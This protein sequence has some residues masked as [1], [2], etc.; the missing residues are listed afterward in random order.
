MKDLNNYLKSGAGETGSGKVECEE[1]HAN[2]LLL[3]T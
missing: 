1:Y 2:E 3:S